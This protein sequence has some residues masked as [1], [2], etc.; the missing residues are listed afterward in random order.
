MV[1][2]APARRQTEHTALHEFSDSST[3]FK[4]SHEQFKL[5][6]CASSLRKM[7][8]PV[9][10]TLLAAIPVRTPVRLYKSDISFLHKFVEFHEFVELWKKASTNLWNC[11]TVPRICARLADRLAVAGMMKGLASATGITA[12]TQKERTATRT[13]ESSFMVCVWFTFDTSSSRGEE[14]NVVFATGRLEL[15]C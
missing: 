7:Q 1:E 13:F 12:A 9:R 15:L 3:K 8:I 11:G 6:G 5:R 2:A 14:A 4:P 10:T